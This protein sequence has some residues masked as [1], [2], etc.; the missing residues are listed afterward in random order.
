MRE[1]EKEFEEHSNNKE[2]LDASK[3]RFADHP[4]KLDTAAF[5]RL[6]AKRVS[7]EA[8]KAGSEEKPQQTGETSDEERSWAITDEV[9]RISSRKTRQPLQGREC[10]DRAVQSRD[11]SSRGGYLN[12]G[13]YPLPPTGPHDFTAVNTTK[14][15]T[16]DTP[17]ADTDGPHPVAPPDVDIVSDDWDILSPT[18]V[19]E[20]EDDDLRSLAISC[21]N[22]SNKRKSDAAKENDKQ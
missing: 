6:V 13:V 17:A 20:E 18:D 19:S 4:M 12:K 11:A 9:P 3:K 22:A 21:L 14:S 5:D 16:E 8:E 10:D 2:R 1:I 7:A 15:S